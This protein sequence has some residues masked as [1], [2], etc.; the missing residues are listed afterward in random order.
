MKDNF[1][2]DDYGLSLIAVSVDETGSMNTCTLRW[3]HEH[4]VTD[5]MM[6]EKQLSELLGMKFEDAFPANGVKDVLAEYRKF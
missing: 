4:G 5:H 1:P 2:F 3:N 6:S